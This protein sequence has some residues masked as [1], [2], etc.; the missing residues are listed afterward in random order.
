MGGAIFF[1]W[2]QTWSYIIENNRITIAAAN[3]HQGMLS[4]VFFW[5]IFLETFCLPLFWIF[6]G[7][8]LVQMWYT[9]FCGTIWE[10]GFAAW[11]FAASWGL[12]AVARQVMAWVFFCEW[13]P[14]LR[15]TVVSRTSA[16][17]AVAGGEGWIYSGRREYWHSVDNTYLLSS[18]LIIITPGSSS[19]SL[20]TVPL[21]VNSVS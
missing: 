8:E 17:C 21:I 1:R 4:R 6:G 16:L 2:R 14:W 15:R 18:N 20:T 7:G 10:P 5:G 19:S 11:I 12:A 9:P 13:M 3:I